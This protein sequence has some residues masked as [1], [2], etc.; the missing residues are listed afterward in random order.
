MKL[1][2]KNQ[3]RK[4]IWNLHLILTSIW[5]VVQLCYLNSTMKVKVTLLNIFFIFQV[6]SSVL[7]HSEVTDRVEELKQIKGTNMSRKIVWDSI[8]EATKKLFTRVS[9]D[10]REYFK[11]L[12][13]YFDNLT[14]KELVYLNKKGLNLFVE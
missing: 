5:L 6:F 8:S 7:S 14:D 4:S 1:V 3:M 13:H 10:K 11:V 12:T 9:V 2:L